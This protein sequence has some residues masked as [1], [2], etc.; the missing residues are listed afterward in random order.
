MGRRLLYRNTACRISPDSM[1]KKK[2]KYPKYYIPK[3]D[4]W[5][6]DF[7]YYIL[8]DYKGNMTHVYKNT[9]SRYNGKYDLKMFKKYLAE[10]VLE[11]VSPAELVLII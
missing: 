8:N 9:R 5:N 11:E 3:G 2:N 6:K 4:G 10:G 7:L 1:K